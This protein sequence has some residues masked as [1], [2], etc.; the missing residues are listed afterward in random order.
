M[1]MPPATN[2]IVPF[3][4]VLLEC[5]FLVVPICAHSVSVS[6]NLWSLLLS[7]LAVPCTLLINHVQAITLHCWL[8]GAG[9][10][11]S[12]WSCS[13]SVSP[14][15]CYTCRV[16]FLRKLF[17]PWLCSSCLHSMPHHLARSYLRMHEHMCEDITETL[18]IMHACMHV[19][20]I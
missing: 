3:Q 20:Y 4:H 2:G 12:W 18:T 9:L 15:C 5:L 6:D 8:L 19:H 11:L 7:Y 17:I 10:H 1:A 13:L 16:K 14:V